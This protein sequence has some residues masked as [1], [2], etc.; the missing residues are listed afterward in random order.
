MEPEIIPA[1]L[2]KRKE[3]LLERI[4]RVKGKVKSVHIDVMDNAFVPNKTV[5]PDDFEGLPEGV[6][7]EFHWMV[8]QPEKWIEKVKGKHLHVVH[9]EAVENWQAIKEACKKVGGK[10][11][12]AISPAT[13]LTKLEPVIKDVSMIL[14]MSVTP[15]F[16]GQKYIQQVEGRIRELRQRYPKMEIEVDG[17]IGPATAGRAHSAGADKLAAASAIYAQPDAGKAIEEIRK[18]AKNKK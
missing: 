15:G 9:I 2:V 11:G 8:K 4:S 10:L 12:I 16:D 13:S 14:V 7:Y 5:G 18:A 1:I 17:G 3:D 6:S